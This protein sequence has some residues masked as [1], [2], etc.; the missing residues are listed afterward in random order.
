MEI[1]CNV[2]TWHDAAMSV[3]KAYKETIAK[4]RDL[5]EEDFDDPTRFT[6][7]MQGACIFSHG[8]DLQI[9]A[10]EKEIEELYSEIAKLKGD[11]NDREN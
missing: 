3:I 4:D 8:K 9:Q 5:N 1:D 7:L 10:L 6:L 11:H 2:D